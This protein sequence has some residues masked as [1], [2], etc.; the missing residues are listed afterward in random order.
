MLLIELLK[1]RPWRIFGL[2]YFLSKMALTSNEDFKQK[3]KNNA[4]G[5]L[6]K[7]LNDIGLSKALH[8][9]KNKV[10]T[11]YRQLVLIS[12]NNDLQDQCMVLVVTASPSFAI[13]F[14]L[15]DLS[16]IVLGTEFEKKEGFYTGFLE[17]KNCYGQEKVNRINQW[18]LSN[19]IILNVK[20]AWSDHFSDYNM[21]NLSKERNWIG[22]E[23]L[24]NL[25]IDNDPKANF[26]C[27]KEAS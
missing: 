3:Y 6:I 25:L 10:N 11:I 7:G 19:N 20:S 2:I 9:F 4:V 27:S 13:K 15:S 16:V 12:I 26:I 5:F 24:R 14:C 18:A 22:G 21:L 23:Q 1:L 17:G 8:G